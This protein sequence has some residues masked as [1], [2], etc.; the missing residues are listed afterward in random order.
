MIPKSP[1]SRLD[2]YRSVD[3]SIKEKNTP[4]VSYLVDFDEKDKVFKSNIPTRNDNRDFQQYNM[5]SKKIIRSEDIIIS[6]RN[7]SLERP[8]HE[9]FSTN[10]VLQKPSN[11]VTCNDNQ[12]NLVNIKPITDITFEKTSNLNTEEKTQLLNKY[13]A[14]MLNENNIGKF[15]ELISDNELKIALKLLCAQ[16]EEDIKPIYNNV[17]ILPHKEQNKLENLLTNIKRIKA[18][19]SNKQGNKFSS[20]TFYMIA[21]LFISKKLLTGTES[22][23]KQLLTE[24]LTHEGPIFENGC[25]GKIKEPNGKNK[26]IN[27]VKNFLKENGVS[28]DSIKKMDNEGGLLKPNSSGFNNLNNIVYDP[29]LNQINFDSTNNKRPI[30]DNISHLQH[31]TININDETPIKSFSI[32]KSA[33]QSTIVKLKQRAQTYLTEFTTYLG[34]IKAPESKKNL[35]QMLI[36]LLNIAN[37]AQRKEFDGE[38]TLGTLKSLALPFVKAGLISNNP[39]DIDDFIESIILVSTHH[40]YWQVAHVGINFTAMIIAK[41]LETSGITSVPQKI[42]EVIQNDKSS[43]YSSLPPDIASNLKSYLNNSG[44]SIN[45]FS[46]EANDIIKSLLNLLIDGDNNTNPTGYTAIKDNMVK[47]HEDIRKNIIAANILAKLESNTDQKKAAQELFNFLEKTYLIPM[48]D[49]QNSLNPQEQKRLASTLQQDIRNEVNKLMYQ[50]E[51]DEAF[52][53]F[54]RELDKIFMKVGIKIN[55]NNPESHQELT[56]QIN[57]LCKFLDES[58]LNPSNSVKMTI[59]LKQAFPNFAT[60]Q[61]Y[62]EEVIVLDG[63]SYY[64]IGCRE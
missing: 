34:S 54:E 59:A 14:S 35:A 24:Y 8:K 2:S 4:K 47:P 50:L 12:S 33:N 23:V 29:A 42:L 45:T 3:K 41:G 27:A 30:L 1:S 15:N 56:K 11:M 10:K 51:K 53:D 48:R 37:Q 13:A 26:F 60:K 58:F 9:K 39:A 32:R 57:E 64:D 7:P 46:N 63:D 22:D 17:K 19:Q 16:D 6:L 38:I 49:P 43:L 62:N 44:D 5:P 18:M 20:S 31:A 36:D 40:N 61:I 21:L 28:E 52:K 55:T 25:L